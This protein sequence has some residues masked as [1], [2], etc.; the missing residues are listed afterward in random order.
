MADISPEP[1]AHAILNSLEI[2][3][4]FRCFFPY[5]FIFVFCISLIRNDFEGS[6]LGWPTGPHKHCE[7]VESFPGPEPGG[8]TYSFSYSFFFLGSLP[9]VWLSSRCLHIFYTILLVKIARNAVSR[10]V[11]L[12]VISFDW[13][14]P[15]IPS[16]NLQRVDAGWRTTWQGASH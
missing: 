3:W 11:S 15:K 7:G 16:R 1:S 9:W 4:A 14:A 5:F 6:S 12:W 8:F 13:W 2:L 10:Y